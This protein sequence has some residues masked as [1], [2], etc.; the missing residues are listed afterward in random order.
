M[1]AARSSSFCANKRW[2]VQAGPQRTVAV[3]ARAMSLVTGDVKSDAAS[4]NAII[5]VTDAFSSWLDQ[6]S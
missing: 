4:A 3:A 6:R 5:F 2:E 1:L